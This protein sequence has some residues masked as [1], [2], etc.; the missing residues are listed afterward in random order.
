[1]TKF[2]FVD[3][4]REFLGAAVLIDDD[5]DW[6]EATE[7]SSSET[8]DLIEPDDFSGSAETEE[9]SSGKTDTSVNAEAVVDGFSELGLVCS[10][11]RW[12]ENH[13]K[14]PKSTEKADLIV[15]DWKL[16]P[17]NEKIALGILTERLKQDL[18]ER[19]RLR[20]IAIYTSESSE[21]VLNAV[22]EGF[23]NDVSAITAARKGDAVHVFL[24]SGATIWRVGHFSKKIQGGMLATHILNDFADFQD[25][26]LPR[27]VM[28][29][30]AEIKRS[31]YEH[32]F[33]FGKS[34]DP[35]LATHLLDKRISELEFPTSRDSFAEFATSLVLA[36]ISAALHSSNL[37][38]S[39]TG[40]TDLTRCLGLENPK[41]MGVLRDQLEDPKEFDQEQLE[42]VFFSEDYDK[43]ATVI[44]QGLKLNAK[45]KKSF[46]EGK[47]PIALS[48]VQE[49]DLT[50][51]AYLDQINSYPKKSNGSYALKS[52]TIL[53]RVP[54]TEAEPEFFLCL[55]PLCDSVRLS[56]PTSFPLLKLLS[57]SAKQKFS[58]PIKEEKGYRYLTSKFK[59][60]D[61][62][63]ATFEP[64]AES[65]DV[66]SSTSGPDAT[67]VFTCYDNNE[68][69]WIGE[70]K[71]HYAAEAQGALATQGGRIGNDKFEW[72]R[73]KAS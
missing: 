69:V 40:K 11:Y 32:L 70:L 43:F 7:P 37:V 54:D 46:R 51:L 14:V 15:I 21:K 1:M 36:D 58:F 63:M 68:F 60:S 30:V 23:N 29:A 8:V 49:D 45:K 66:R 33:R 13:E 48:T 44:E 16:K 10:T 50:A 62:N 24:D 53:K 55:Q 73:R 25:G 5:L 42:T 3:I 17:G 47:A 28:A 52:G 6:S 41:S 72:L 61:V 71:P 2:D 19:N 39:A 59:L 20:Y 64:N 12:R 67:Q 4:P 18:S 9:Q 22:V 57:V 27:T 56:G 26:V 65:R 38:A 35:A 34:L 31:A